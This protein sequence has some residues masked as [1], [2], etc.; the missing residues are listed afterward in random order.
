MLTT[1]LATAS[2]GLLM[3]S[4]T[5][6]PFTPVCWPDGAHRALTIP[7]LLRLTGHPADS[8]V[9]VLGLDEFFRN[10]AYPQPWH[11]TTQAAQVPRF[12]RLVEV[13]RGRLTG[14]RVYRVDSVRIDVYIVGTSGCTLAGLSTVVV[15]T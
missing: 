3:P 10:V 6:A 7:R 2:T 11:D 14:V 15:E 9:E 4:E 13:L 8:P 5:D 12:R 1:T